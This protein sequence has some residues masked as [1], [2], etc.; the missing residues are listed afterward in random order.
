MC[1][2]HEP[3]DDFEDDYGPSKS[4]QKK[5]MDRLQAL[6]E[7][8]GEMRDDQLR[9]L[10]L[11]ESLLHALIELKRLKAH[12]AVRRHKQ[13][14]GKLMRHADEAAI[15][16]ALNP[17]RSPAL[18]RQ[19][20]LL[21][22]RLLQQGDELLSEVLQRYPAADRHTLRQLVRLARKEVETVAADVAVS[23]ATHPARHKLWIY[24]RELAALAS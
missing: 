9:K 19:L 23:D 16:N 5:S 12:E 11:E 8:L 10:P 17:L 2:R 21:L 22:E 4:D 6:G 1:P 18:Q 7:R 15:L 3:Q 14:I 20:D 24:L 13:F